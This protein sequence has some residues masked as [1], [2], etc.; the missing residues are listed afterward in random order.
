MI[1]Y[2]EVVTATIQFR[3]V[4]KKMESLQN[5]L[6]DIIQESDKSFGDIRHYIELKDTTMTRHEKTV[7]CRA[8][9]TVSNE[10]RKAKN[11][12]DVLTPMFEYLSSH[13]Q[14]MSDMGRLANDLKKAKEKVEKPHA[15]RVRVLT[16]IF[17]ENMIDGEVKLNE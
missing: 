2:N 14:F 8:M 17:G 4:V 3:D 16:N 7:V 1:D 11:A 13:K 10:R 9:K 15:Y 6:E 12:K 5:I